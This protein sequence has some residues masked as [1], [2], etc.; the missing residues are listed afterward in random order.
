M[1]HALAFD[2]GTTG[3]K[4]C[5]FRIQDT[6][7][8]LDS[9][10]STYELHVLPGGGAEQDPNDWWAAIVELTRLLR[11]RHPE[12]MGDLSG[13]TFCA[14]MQ[15][16]VMVDRDGIPVH[17]AFSYMDQRASAEMKKQVGRG[18]RIA[19]VNAVTALRTLRRT[20]AV[21]A[22]VKDPVWKYHWLR[23][24]CPEEFQR[25]YKWLDVKEA[26]IARMTGKFIMSQDSAFATLLYDIR[27]DR[28]R[29]D[30]LTMKLL[31]VEPRHMPRIINSSDVVGGLLVKPAA[32]LGLP[33]GTPVYA[34]GG[35][36]SL[37]GVGAGATA[38][39]DTHVYMGTSGW[40]STVTDKQ[41]VDIASMIAAIVGADPQRY[42]YFAEL[43][44]AGKC[45]E[46]VRDHLALDE[47]N[48]FLEKSDVTESEESIHSSLYDY[49]SEVIGRA[50][51][52][53]GGVLFAPWL[54]GNRS[55][56]EDPLARALFL[57]ISLD[58]GKTELL[59]AV[60]EGVCFH[61]RWFLETQEKRV[62]TSSRLR[63]VGGGALSDVT[64][65]ILADVTQR[66]VDVV[67][68]PQDVGAVGAALLVAVGEG[69][70]SGVDQ[71]KDLVKVA[72]S[73]EPNRANKSVY[74][75]QFTAFKGLH[76]ANKK[77][78]Q[79]LNG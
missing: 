33:V 13:I 77:L 41:T 29:F 51:P 63:F 45:L 57:N 47:I 37:I 55:P 3:V 27:A 40:V 60:V 49:L 23:Q 59:R 72:A 46:W 18:P 14:Q 42:N 30:E 64:S 19:G 32:E 58:T 10:T 71:A 70:I 16:M 62:S 36:A 28:P 65:Q 17:N 68:H 78:F 44:T 34:G 35:D 2:I 25:G 54:H 26:V 38:L 53:A 1:I 56:F 76:K 39:G 31:G 20:G 67:D 43:E 9:E 21:A 74:D 48:V 6:V 8:K 50:E 69:M 11:T 24:H 73:F 52:G 75:R 66:P 7:T 22:S 4:A 12:A 5:L 61:M 79:A 15:A